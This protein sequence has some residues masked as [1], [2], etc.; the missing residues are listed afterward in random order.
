MR[1]YLN[2]QLWARFSSERQTNVWIWV[3][4]VSRLVSC[5]PYSFGK[6]EKYCPIFHQHWS[7]NNDM[8]FEF[9]NF[10]PKLTTFQ[11]FTN[12]QRVTSLFLTFCRMEV[13]MIKCRCVQVHSCRQLLW[14]NSCFWCKASA[15]KNPVLISSLEI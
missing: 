5:R 14:Y 8:K 9:S 11:L 1:V 10:W 3:Q 12:A 4:C 13:S 6:N 15:A 7:G 2:F